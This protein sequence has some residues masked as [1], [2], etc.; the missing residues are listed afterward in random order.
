MSTV[1]SSSLPTPAVTTIIKMMESLPTGAHE[2]VVEHLRDY[3]AEMQDEQKWDF[4]FQKTQNSLADAAR[5]AK[6][7]IAAGQSEPM[8]QN[9][10]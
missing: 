3:I 6:A 9:R 4:S 8:D 2:Q 10:L 5:K 7:E 1:P